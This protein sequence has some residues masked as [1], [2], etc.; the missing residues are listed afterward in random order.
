MRNIR[1]RLAASLL[2]VLVIVAILGV[3]LALFVSAVHGVRQ[4]AARAGCAN[5]LRQIGLALHQHHNARKSFPPG[6]AHPATRPLRPPIYGPDTDPYPLLNWHARILPYLD[7]EALWPLIHEAYAQDRYSQD[8]PPHVVRTIR[9]PVFLCTADSPPGTLGKSPGTT[10]Y[11]GVSGENGYLQD[12][13]LF[14]DSA[15]RLTDITDGASNTLLVGERPPSRN[16][17]FGRW[18]GSWG[19]WGTANAYLGVQETEVSLPRGA[20]CPSGPYEF[21][22]GSLLNRCSAYH[23]W[24]LHPGGAHFLAADGAVHF[25]PYTAAHLL[26]ALASR[27][28]RDIATFGD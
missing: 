17:D 26:P 11:L 10:S 23:F 12:G 2:E 8:N 1:F 25:L 13:V 28:G 21:T 18:Y 7:H 9:I 5:H 19:P 27:D 15:V 6:V 3:L 24:S 22:K 16:F 20:K 4:T 14:L